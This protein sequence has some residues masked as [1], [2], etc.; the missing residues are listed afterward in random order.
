[1]MLVNEFTTTVSA[2]AIDFRENQ[3]LLRSEAAKP[4]LLHLTARNPP[5]TSPHN[6]FTS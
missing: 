2:V 1:M 5:T 6:P 3:P 4:S